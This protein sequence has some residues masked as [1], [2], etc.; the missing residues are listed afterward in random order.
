M[1]SIALALIVACGGSS[2]AVDSGV[3]GCGDIGDTHVT[4]NDWLG[5]PPY[6]MQGCRL[7]YV[8][9]PTGDLVLRDLTLGTS[10]VLEPATSTPRRPAMASDVVAWEA[11]NGVRVFFNDATTTMPVPAGYDHTGEP[12]AATSI[13]VVTAWRS[14]AA[15]S[16]TDVLAYD[17]ASGAF[18]PIIVAPKQQ[19]FATV[20]ET[21]IAVTDFTE[22]PIGAYTGSGNDLAD[23][24]VFTR[25]SSS[26]VV[27]QRPGKDAFP[28]IITNDV[29]GYLHWGDVHP[30]PKLEAYTLYSGTIG[31]DPAND[32][33]IA[34]V[35]N[36]FALERPSAKNGV[37]EWVAT[38]QSSSTLWRANVMTAGAPTAALTV[39]NESLLGSVSLDQ[40]TLV[41]AGSVL[42][43]V[44]R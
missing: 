23:I 18:T 20:S 37:M 31:A 12:A 44:S 42:R 41:A 2:Y 7:A 15:D 4:P 32:T 9:G 21:I 26:Y 6:A 10:Q 33:M 38:L 29:L 5:Y 24:G 16:D 13:V 43:V 34:D 3:P 17:P 27:R 8:D 14:A 35:T 22:D 40:G 36:A 1:R 25:S 30:E 39:S 28:V 19:R 11:Q